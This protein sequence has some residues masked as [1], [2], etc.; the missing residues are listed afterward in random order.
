VSKGFLLLLLHCHLPFVRHP[1]HPRFLEE[2]WLFEGISETY[3]P[4][5][6]ILERLREERVSVKLTV[7]ISPTLLSMLSDELLQERYARHLERL[8]ELAGKETERTRSQPHFNRLAWMYLDLVTRNYEQFTRKYGRNLIPHLAK[9]E[10]VGVVEL[11]TSA[12]TH[13]YLPLLEKYPQAVDAQIG[14]AVQMHEKHLG[15]RPRGIWLPECGYYPGLETFLKKHGLE[16]FFVDTHGIL[17]ADRRPSY[18]NYAPIVCEN[19]VA[20][21]ARDPEASRAVWS[22]EEGY[23]GDISY[24]EF[25][26]DIGY[27]LPLEY[28][29]P[30]I[31]EGDVRINTGIKYYA[32]TGPGDRKKPYNREEAMKKVEEHSE[33]FIY[34]R[35]NQVERIGGL[36]DRPPLIVAPFDAELFGHWWFEGP[37]WLESLLKKIDRGQDDLQLTT[38]LE[39]LLLF[40]EN[41]VATPSFSS[42]G[43]KGYSEVWLS[44]SNDWIYRHVHKAVER[45]KR[46]AKLFVSTNGVRRRALNQATREL[47]LMQASDWAFI[48]KTGTTVPYAVGRVREHVHNFNRIYDSLLTN[49]L[50][51]AWLTGLEARNNIFPDVDYRIFS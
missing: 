7:S 8:L 14:L 2:D 11:I 24:R 42:W 46:L 10:K 40:R 37:E 13:A 32:I 15:S 22:A 29:R 47:L 17:Y 33:N 18:G 45:M 30:Y 16:Y 23:P 48:M 50:D 3:L 36:M 21:F 25:Y 4:L 34:S 20:A 31:H 35:R 28:I 49:Q 41:Q 43:N 27:D 1:D 51:L 6:R 39:Y 9:L 19:G 44:G 38:P 26:R 5:L 12:A